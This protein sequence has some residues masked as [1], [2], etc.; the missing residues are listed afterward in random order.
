MTVDQVMDELHARANPDNIAGM[1]RFG[2]N[3]AQ[4]LGISVTELRRLARTIGRDHQL[5]LDLWASGIH[6]AR[7]L[8]SLVDEPDCVTPEQ[9]DVWVA[10]FDSWDV[11]DQV[12]GNLF[13]RT[14]FAFD[15]VAE[16]SYRDEEFV[17]R[18][19]FALLAELAINDKRA[20]DDRFLACFSLIVAA[21]TDE[22]NYVKKAVNWALRQIGK[23]N[24]ALNVHALDLSRQIQQIDSRAARWIASDA[25][26]ELMSAPV[27]EKLQR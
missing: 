16:W 14:P 9:M 6:E 5:A 7:I 12:C 23:R 3:S 20:P 11:C 27:Q 21:A 18:A 24:P 2:I 22:R 25:L 10:D 13:D 8:A 19:A 1:A 15:K 26:R 4:A 17:R